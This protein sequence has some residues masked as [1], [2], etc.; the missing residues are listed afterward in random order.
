VALILDTSV[1]LAALDAADPDHAPCAELIEAANEN[2]LVP[3]LVLSELDYWCGE[4]LTADVWT[5]FLDDV[6][7]GAY[8]VESPTQGDLERCREL[9]RAYADL[10]VGVVDA[11]IL[12]L[13]ERLGEAKLA[14]LDH[15]H[16]ATMR[17]RHIDALELL[18][19]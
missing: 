10:K 3:M 6:L 7:A 8:S 16:F 19:G 11:S 15:R 18:P 13:A 2:L 1:L 4:R 12:A 17:P 14:S 9:Q 5:A